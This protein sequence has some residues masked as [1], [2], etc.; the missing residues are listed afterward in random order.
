MIRDEAFGGKVRTIEVPKRNPI[1]T[2]NQLPDFTISTSSSA[3][4]TM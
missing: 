4:S 2:R 3:S 1:A